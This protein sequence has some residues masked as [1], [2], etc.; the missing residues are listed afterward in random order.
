M[1]VGLRYEGNVTRLYFNRF[2]PMR[3]A[4][5]RGDPG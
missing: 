1:G 4:M 5:K 3:F 2:G